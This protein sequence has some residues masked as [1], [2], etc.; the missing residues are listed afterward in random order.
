M[1]KIEG[2]DIK[3]CN[4][5]TDWIINGEKRFK[6]KKRYISLNVIWNEM[7]IQLDSSNNNN[8]N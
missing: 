8:N 3:E 4:Y 1:G 2:N 6:Q 5:P 7:D